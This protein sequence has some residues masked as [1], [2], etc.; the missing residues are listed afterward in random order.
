MWCQIL[1]VVKSRMRR[2]ESAAR[3]ALAAAPVASEAPVAPAASAAFAAPAAI[4]AP[5]SPADA[6]APAAPAAPAASAG[7][8]WPA[9]FGLVSSAPA[10][11]PPAGI[12]VCDSGAWAPLPAAAS[13]A[14]AASA[15]RESGSKYGFV[16][17]AS[18]LSSKCCGDRVRAHGA[19]AGREPRS[20]CHGHGRYNMLSFCPPL[21]KGGPFAKGRPVCERAARPLRGRVEEDGAPWICCRAGS[22]AAGWAVFP[23]AAR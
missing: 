7:L 2:A 11:G 17:D 12:A 8:A 19:A 16:K 1:P 23:G 9:S 10:P 14:A 22:A 3:G 15:I 5:A 18:S 4:A 6:A 13:C 20:S 21:R